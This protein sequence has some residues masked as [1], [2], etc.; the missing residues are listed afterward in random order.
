MA[1]SRKIKRRRLQRKGGQMPVPSSWSSGQVAS[2]KRQQNQVALVNSA[3]KL[4]QSAV[5]EAMNIFNSTRESN[6]PELRNIETMIYDKITPVR[7][8]INNV[9]QLPSL[10]TNFRE[11]LSKRNSKRKHKTLFM[12]NS[13]NSVQPSSSRPP[14]LYE[15]QSSAARQAMAQ[16]QLEAQASA[17]MQE[18]ALMQQELEASAAMQAQSQAPAAMQEQSQAPSDMQDQL[19]A[20]AAMQ[21]QAL[22]QQELEASAAMQAQAQ[23][24]A[25]MQEQSQAPSD[26]Q[27]Q[28]QASAAMQDQLQASAA[29]QELTGGYRKLRKVRGGTL[30]IKSGRKTRRRSRPNRRTSRKR[31]TR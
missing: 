23:A 6:I 21:E 17:A 30:S 24:P 7:N 26:M 19:Q 16:E 5:D 15:L 3:N 11:E 4:S 27:D 25:A 22:M 18:Q 2:E 29:M 13:T 14:K 28:L 12:N 10:P 8:M 1:R 9:K 20:S 31:T